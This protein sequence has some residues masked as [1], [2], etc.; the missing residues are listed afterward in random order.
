MTDEVT[1]RQI[2]LILERLVERTEQANQALD[3]LKI[4]M[5]SLERRVD[6][7]IREVQVLRME[8]ADSDDLSPDRVIQ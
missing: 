1:L 8:R 3:A 7:L 2:A 6:D 5:A 4:C